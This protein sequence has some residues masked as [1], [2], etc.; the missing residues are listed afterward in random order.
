MIPAGRVERVI[1]GASVVVL[2]S[3]LLMFLPSGDKFN[4][5]DG[6]PRFQLIVGMYYGVAGLV[7]LMH[8]RETVSVASRSRSLV[9][10]IALTI[11]SFLW[12]QDRSLVLRHALAAVGTTLV[13]IL[14]ASRLDSAERLVLIRRVLRILAVVSVLMAVL[15]PSY[16]V[17]SVDPLH[18][19]DWTGVYGNKNGLG[20]YASIALLMDVYMLVRF[21]QKV[22]WLGLY[23]LLLIKSGSVSPLVALAGTGFS[24]KLFKRLRVRHGL[25]VKAIA[26][27]T[28]GS[29]TLI[30]VG[31]VGTGFLPM[32]LGRSTDL[33]GRTGLWKA[34]V[35]AILKHPLLGYGY[36]GFWAGASSEYWIVDRQLYW[37]PMYSHN[38]YLEIV[39]SLGILGLVLAVCFLA[40]AGVFAFLE[41]DTQEGTSNSFPLALLIFFLI[42]NIT[43]CTI[44]TANSFEWALVVA[45]LLGVMPRRVA[46]KQ[47]Y[48]LNRHEEALTAGEEYA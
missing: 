26:L 5:I 6:N 21:R 30:V 15:L 28:F 39:V 9:G 42:Q 18:I 31:I 40:R 41:A 36:D 27:S 12:A 46:H 19:G 47:E 11:L 7:A 38:G 8:F 20:A 37:S 44:L 16:G 13:G 48:P 45:M 35:P 24:L 3:A 17:E 43:E 34:L 33:S 29:M 14:L 2:S 32:V 22:F 1:L 25:S 23:L 4:Y 10:L